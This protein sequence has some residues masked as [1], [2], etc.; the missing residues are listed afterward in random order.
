MKTWAT[1]KSVTTLRLCQTCK[2]ETPHEIHTGDGCRCYV[3]VPCKQRAELY[4]Q[5]RD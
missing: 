3:C 4:E 5:N 2:K 1:E